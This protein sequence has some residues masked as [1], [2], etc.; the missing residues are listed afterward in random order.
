M[1]LNLLVEKALSLGI[2]LKIREHPYLKIVEVNL[3]HLM[4][5]MNLLKKDPVH[6]FD[7]LESHTA[8]DRIS[9]ERFEM[10]YQLY[11]TTNRDYLMVCTFTPRQNPIVP[12]MSPLWKIAEWQEREV[13]DLFGIV[14]ENHPDL[15]R[16]FLDD[17][18]VGF[19]LR[20]DYKDDFMLELPE[21]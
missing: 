14:Y 21:K 3:A 2:D 6:A 9:D 8:V 1:D 7:L 12:T 19:P 20:K 13:Y 17:D 15:R 16:L 11:S 4:S 5:L 18:W 10:I